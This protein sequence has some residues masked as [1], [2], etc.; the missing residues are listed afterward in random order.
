MLVLIIRMIK[1]TYF[2]VL[3]NNSP[4]LPPFSDRFN[5][6]FTITFYRKTKQPP[7]IN[8]EGCLFLFASESK[9]ILCKLVA[10]HPSRG[11]ASS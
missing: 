3:L 1:Q 9:T 6:L 11:K 4:M 5:T 7:E 2:I 10:C 8:S